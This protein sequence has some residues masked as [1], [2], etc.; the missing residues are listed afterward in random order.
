MRLVALGI[1]ITAFF[2]WVLTGCGDDGLSGSSDA[3]GDADSDT[4]T[5]TG[6]VPIEYPEVMNPFMNPNDLM[7][8]PISPPPEDVMDAHASGDGPPGPD[9]TLEEVLEGDIMHDEEGDPDAGS[10]DEEL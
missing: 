8:G 7:T 3:G 1:L 5:E 6:D 9:P 4:D 10:S 2:F